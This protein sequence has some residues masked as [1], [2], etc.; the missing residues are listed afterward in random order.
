M[1]RD[2]V[3]RQGT[4][5]GGCG[6]RVSKEPTYVCERDSKFKAG[7]PEYLLPCRLDRL[8]RSGPIECPQKR[9]QPAGGISKFSHLKQTTGAGTKKGPRY[10]S[11][12]ALVLPQ[13]GFA[14]THVPTA[15][16]PHGD[17]HSQDRRHAEH[18][19]HQAACRR[20][21]HGRAPWLL[22]FHGDA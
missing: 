21:W 2:G 8:M 1:V 19:R 13:E 6:F 5:L 12:G 17:D 7:E 14:S 16:E 20:P 9:V 22:G 15:E 18:N 10:G 4:R 11:E 3:E